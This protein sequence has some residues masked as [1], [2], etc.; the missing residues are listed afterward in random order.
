MNHEIMEDGSIKLVINS[1]VHNIDTVNAAGYSF[2]DK[3]Y[4]VLDYEN[5]NIIVKLYPKTNQDLKNL[6]LEFHNQLVNYSNFF[7]NQKI[8]AETNKT[9]I[10][11]ALFSAN[12]G[13][14]EEAEDQEVNDLLKELEDDEDEEIK[15]AVQDIK[16][17]N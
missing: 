14:I 4:V 9:I 7:N 2:L 8:N 6:G 16:N 17:E 15:Q 1:K 3:V 13:L 11:R 10:E 5:E 12:P